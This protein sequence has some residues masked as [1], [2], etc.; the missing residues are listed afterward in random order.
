MFVCLFVELLID[1][2][3]T[4]EALL[5]FRAEV[6]LF[7]STDQRHLYFE[8]EEEKISLMENLG[9]KF[10]SEDSDFSIVC[11]GKEIRC[12][13]L[14]LA[15]QSE[16]FKTL[17]TQTGMR[18]VTKKRAVFNEN[19]SNNVM[20]EDIEVDTMHLL[21]SY[22]YSLK[23]PESL[24]REQVS[25]L[26]VAADRLQVIIIMLLLSSCFFKYIP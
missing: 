25:E 8:E 21:L 20:I 13:K 6:Q 9:N 26:L 24:S 14:I 2:S 11:E 12:H 23:L 17:F 15:S 22:L 18:T 19:D 5:V 4:G 16:Y 7:Y 3:S 10:G 1:C